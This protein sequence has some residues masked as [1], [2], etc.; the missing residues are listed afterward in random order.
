MHTLPTHTAHES[1]QAQPMSALRHA[2]RGCAIG[3]RGRF[4]AADTN[5]S[6][7]CLGQERVLQEHICNTSEGVQVDR[8]ELREGTSKSAC[9]RRSSQVR[10]RVL[11]FIPLLVQHHILKRGAELSDMR[12]T[13]QRQAWPLPL[14]LPCHCP[15]P[16]PAAATAACP[17]PCPCPNTL[18][19]TDI[20]HGHA[21]HFETAA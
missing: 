2:G 15:H 8:W 7:V 11:L 6:S 4:C 13:H 12:I 1:L 16:A 9:G 14:P 18:L 10:V 20:R 19:G 3:R 5:T 17:R 21:E